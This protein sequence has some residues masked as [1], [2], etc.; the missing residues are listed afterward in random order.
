VKSRHAGDVS[1]AREPFSA[2]LSQIGCFSV[3]F[4]GWAAGLAFLFPARLRRLPRSL[5]S[6]RNV[7]KIVMVEIEMVRPKGNSYFFFGGRG[8]SIS[9]GDSDAGVASDLSPFRAIS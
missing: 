1:V 2:Y 9:E 6:I 8:I 4:L 7:H 3:L 5:V